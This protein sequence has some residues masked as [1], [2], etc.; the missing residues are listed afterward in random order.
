MTGKEILAEQGIR[1]LC[2]DY[3]CMNRGNYGRCYMHIYVSCPFYIAWKELSESRQPLEHFTSEKQ[4]KN[5][6]RML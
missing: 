3:V 6:R 2:D 4:F 5:I 1:I